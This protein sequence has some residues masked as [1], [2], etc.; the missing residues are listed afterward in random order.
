MLCDLPKMASRNAGT[1]G[2][3]QKPDSPA[4][5]SSPANGFASSGSASG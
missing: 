3:P 4:T 5:L 2:G 1:M